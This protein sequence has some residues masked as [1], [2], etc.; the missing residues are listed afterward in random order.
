MFVFLLIWY[1]LLYKLLLD[2]SSSYKYLNFFIRNFV[3]IDLHIHPILI[4]YVKE[5]TTDINYAKFH[6][7]LCDKDEMVMHISAACLCKTQLIYMV[8]FFKIIIYMIHEN[9]WKIQ[10]EHIL[11]ENRRGGT[12]WHMNRLW[13]MATRPTYTI[14]SSRH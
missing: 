2:D 12:R 4:W 10:C 8:H 13:V 1:L 7:K 3:K 11:T 9:W 6:I 14:I 5:K